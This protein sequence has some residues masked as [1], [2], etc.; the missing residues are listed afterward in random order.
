MIATDYGNRMAFLF[1]R[2]SKIEACNY[3]RK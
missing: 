3:H 2:I 1:S